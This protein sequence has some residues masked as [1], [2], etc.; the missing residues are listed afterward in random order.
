[1]ILCDYFLQCMYVSIPYVGIIK[2]PEV[3]THS[4]PDSI[5]LY[6][7]S[8]LGSSTVSPNEPNRV[9]TLHIVCWKSSEEAVK[10]TKAETDM[11]RT[12]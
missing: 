9:L 12:S 10:K 2:A 4:T 5:V 8:S 1:M 3:I 6:L 11:T 7:H